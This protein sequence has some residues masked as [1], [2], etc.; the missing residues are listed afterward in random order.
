MKEKIAKC[1]RAIKENHCDCLLISNPVNVTYLSGFRDADGFL[2]I[3]REGKPIYF[4]NPLFAQEARANTQWQVRVSTG[5]IFSLIVKECKRLGVG[6]VGFES[7]H[8]PY[9]EFE[10]FKERLLAQSVDFVKTIDLVEKIRAIKSNAEIQRIRE[11]ASA[12]I[13]TLKF[14][15][16]IHDSS[17][18]EKSL[19]LE[20]EK[21][22][23]IKA[24]SHVAFD[25]IVA[26]GKNT[27]IPHH[28]PGQARLDKNFFLIDLGA[29][30]YGYCADLTR[31]FFWG[32]IPPLFR[33]IYDCVR[34]SH[35]AALRSIRAGVKASAVDRAAREIIEKKGWGKQFVHGLGHGV[36]MLVHEAPYLNSRN[37]DRLAENMVITIEP[38]IYVPGQFGIRIENMA[39]VTS[40]KPQS[41]SE[42]F[43]Y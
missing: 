32:K 13:E 8:L 42:G 3:T 25:T 16:E 19:S 11:A 15:E 30:H 27:C 41:L 29:K 37:D 24:D 17:M 2:L 43:P 21:F 39:L 23:K 28:V 5:N 31:V 10:K 9:L 35:D 26:S 18:T 1:V 20:I 12:T 22:L 34:Q 38:A 4:T 33:K 14:I 7:K 6:C 36:G 40:R